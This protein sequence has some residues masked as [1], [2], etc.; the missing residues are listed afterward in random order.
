MK[1]NITNYEVYFLMY[2]DNELSAEQKIA[3]E[4]FIQENKIHKKEFELLQ[5]AVLAPSP[6]EFEDKFL[7]Y[8]FDEME[9]SLPISFKQSLYRKDAKVIEGF[10]NTKKIRSLYAVA[11]IFLITIAYKLVPTIS[12]KK[13]PNKE[14]TNNTNAQFNK[15]QVVIKADYKS[16]QNSQESMQNN[17]IV[18][19]WHNNKYPFNIL[20]TVVGAKNKNEQEASIVQCIVP[21]NTYLASIENVKQNIP[22]AANNI[23]MATFPE[24]LTNT[25]SIGVNDAK[26]DFE[27]I[28]TDNPDR[29]IYIANMEIDGDK[30]R[31][32]T[33]RIG[34]II[35]RNKTEKENK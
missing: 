7:L 26:Q 18:N 24:K 2:V 19:R 31:G 1:I 27:N 11:A 15:K 20:P 16:K 10:F 29:T 8:R 14:L 30:L 13:Y 9:A 3:V 5:Q 4:N 12:E 32:L 34:A 33:R 28:D 22:I 17:G 21:R 23:A 6:I 25:E 35:K